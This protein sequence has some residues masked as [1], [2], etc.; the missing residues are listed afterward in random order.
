LRIPPYAVSVV[1][2]DD[3]V[4]PYALWPRVRVRP[5]H[6]L[7]IRAVPGGGG[8]QGGDDNKLLRT[9][10]QIVVIA[11][12]IAI[13]V[14]SEGTALAPAAMGIAAVFSVGANL[15]PIALLPPRPHPAAAVTY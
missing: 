13:V 7:F 3:E 14:L 10:L 9:A 2:I 11:I 8:G 12:A 1:M 15:V 4:V 6:H 5:G